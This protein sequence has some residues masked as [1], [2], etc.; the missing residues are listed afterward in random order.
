MPRANNPGFFL[1]RYG[2]WGLWLGVATSLTIGMS[3]YLQTRIGVSMKIVLMS[4]HVVAFLLLVTAAGLQLNDPDPMYWGGFY[5]V[6]SLVPL[7]AIFRINNWILYAF[8]G[9]YAIAV[10]IP[11]LDG[12][13][14]YLRQTEPLLQQMSSDKPYIEEAREFL[15]ALTALGLVGICAGIQ[16]KKY[17]H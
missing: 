2:R 4:S 6:C 10:I 14:E 16:C 17:K 8:C 1:D 7:L 9:I 11:T 13:L 5:F 15:G 3:L 12:F